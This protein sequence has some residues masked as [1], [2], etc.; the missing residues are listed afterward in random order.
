M[1]E[2][3]EAL[4]KLRESANWSYNYNPD[5]R[6]LEVVEAIIAKIEKL[7]QRI[8]TNDK[9]VRETRVPNK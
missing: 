4:R 6:M 1:K 5:E 3:K 7:E 8:E 2:I 9:W